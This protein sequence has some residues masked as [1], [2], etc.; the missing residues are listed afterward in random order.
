MSKNEK[1]VLVSVDV[2]NVAQAGEE[3]LKIFDRSFAE[4]GMPFY[5]RPLRSA[6]QFVRIAL[7]DVPGYSKEGFAKQDWFMSLVASIAEWYKALYGAETMR[8]PPS[9]FRGLILLMGTPIELSIRETVNRVEVEGET[10][11]MIY[12]SSIHESEE[13]SSFFPSRPNIQSL[14]KNQQFKLEKSVADVVKKLAK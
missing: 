14:S 13:I 7:V 10:A 4:Q 2:R 6:I 12:P 11:W 1:D 5:Q 9:F 3:W 8:P